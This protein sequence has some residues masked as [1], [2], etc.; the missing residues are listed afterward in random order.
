MLE[1]EVDAADVEEEVV[2]DD[3][4]SFSFVA[5]VVVPAESIETE[6][7]DEESLADAA[8][9]SMSLPSTRSGMDHAATRDAA[10]KIVILVMLLGL[11]SLMMVEAKGDECE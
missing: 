11:S 7:T 6:S 2:D 8:A 4:D 10:K 1:E 3:D 9:E 5:A